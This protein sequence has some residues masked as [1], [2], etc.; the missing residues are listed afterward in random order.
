[1]R[2]ILFTLIVMILFPCMAFG[3]EIQPL[4]NTQLDKILQD[5][6]GK[7]VML[8]FFATWCPPC[9]VELPE[10]RKLRDAFPEK[11][12][13]LIGLSVD[14]D[15]SAVPDFLQE[16]GVNYPVYMADKSITDAYG[17][18]SVPHNAFFDPAGKLDIS[19]PGMAEVK[20]LEGVVKQL[21]AR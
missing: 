19:E 15:K 1:M 21:L 12:F 8:N 6:K 2:K 17:I 9:R 10:L 16:A 5:N 7:V 11:E 18:S 20:V 14:E 3:A 4:T 13:M